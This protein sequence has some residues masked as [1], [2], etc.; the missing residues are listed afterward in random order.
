MRI[1]A[2]FNQDLLDAITRLEQTTH[3][4][5]DQERILL[6]MLRNQKEQIEL[7]FKNSNA[8][9]YSLYLTDDEESMIRSLIQQS[10]A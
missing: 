8:F 10:R 2:H 5:S 7:H 1:R 4:H 6:G 9:R 3:Q